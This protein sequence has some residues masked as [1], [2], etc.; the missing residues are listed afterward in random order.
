MLGEEEEGGVEWEGRG[1]MG[2]LRP[3]EPREPITVGLGLSE[4]G[5]VVFDI[6]LVEGEGSGSNSITKQNPLSFSRIVVIQSVAWVGE[7]HCPAILC[8]V[9]NLVRYNRS[10]R[11]RYEELN[12]GNFGCNEELTESEGM[13]NT[14]NIKTHV[15]L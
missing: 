11:L 3:G 7:C 5:R 8:I 15:H 9:Q 4:E 6:E 1:I 12:T 10:F 14:N 13:G 2:L